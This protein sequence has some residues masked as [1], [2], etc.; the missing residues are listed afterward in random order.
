[1]RERVAVAAAGG[2]KI[3]FLDSQSNDITS[4][5]LEELK[6]IGFSMRGFRDGDKVFIKAMKYDNN[7]DKFVF[8]MVHTKTGKEYPVWAS[9]R[10]VEEQLSD[11]TSYRESDK[12]EFFKVPEETVAFYEVISKDPE[13]EG[14]IFFVVGLRGETD[15]DI[16]L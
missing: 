8:R 6:K 16:V 9:K 4:Y 11:L 1:M 7:G 3:H 14:Q 12:A 10:L 15:G 5:N 2:K 13:T